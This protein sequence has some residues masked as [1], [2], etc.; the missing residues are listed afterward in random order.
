ADIDLVK[1]VGDL[2][3]EQGGVG[4]RRD[5]IPVHGRLPVRVDHDNFGSLTL[6]GIHVLGGDRLVVSSHRTPEHQH[7]GADPVPVITA[8]G[9]DSQ[10]TLQRRLTGGVANA[11]GVVDVVSP[12][13]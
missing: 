3:A 5:P 11:G 10:G 4:N 7:I 2:R 9:A 6:G 13:E 12:Q 1:I 8:G